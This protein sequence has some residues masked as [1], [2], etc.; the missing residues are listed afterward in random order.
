MMRRLRLNDDHPRPLTWARVSIAVLVWL[1]M[2]VLILA[3]E[4]LGRG[5]AV[6]TAP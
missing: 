3:F 5:C 1:A 2:L 4:T 6:A